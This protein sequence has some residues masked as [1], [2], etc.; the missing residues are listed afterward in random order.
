[1]S[2]NRHL[3]NRQASPKGS[4]IFTILPVWRSRGLCLGKGLVAADLPATPRDTPEPFQPSPHFLFPSH[5]ILCQPSNQGSRP[6][7]ICIHGDRAA[8]NTSLCS[9]A[10]HR[11]IGAPGRLVPPSRSAWST[12]PHHPR[13]RPIALRASSRSNA[14]RRTTRIILQT[15]LRN[16]SCPRR[17]T[18]WSTRPILRRVRARARS[19]SIA[20]RPLTIARR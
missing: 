18:R 19:A 10:R 16:E 9:T 5:P 14:S 1:M 12:S 6:H 8:V 4:Q 20:K 11:P 17:G 15:W 3:R 13:R 2:A 7:C